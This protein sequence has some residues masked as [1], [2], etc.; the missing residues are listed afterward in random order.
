MKRKA[1]IILLALFIFSALM[2]FTS[3]SFLFPSEDGGKAPTIEKIEVI[4]ATDDYFESKEYLFN[5]DCT[6]PLALDDGEEYYVVLHYD[7]P[8]KLPISYV[9]INGQKINN[10]DFAQGSNTSKTYIYYKVDDMADS[11]ERSYVINSV[12]YVNGSST[13]K[14]KWNSEI[15]AEER[16]ARVTVRPYFTLTLNYMDA[17]RR[18]ASSADSKKNTVESFDNVYYNAEMS[19]YTVTPDYSGESIV[20]TK[21]GS[22]VFAGWFTKPNGEGELVTADDHY[23]F[24]CNVTLYAH[25]ERM[26]N[27]E[28]VELDEPVVYEYVSGNG[29]LKT[30]EFTSG[31]VITNRDFSKNELT[32][33]PTLDLTDTIVMETI[34]YTESVGP[35]GVAVYDVK[36]S[37]S[38]YPIVKIDNNA[39]GKFSTLT[40]VSVGQ[41]VEEIGY[42]AF[43]ACEALTTFNFHEDSV[44]KYIGDYA[45]ESTEALGINPPFTL[46]S[47]VEYLGNFAF[48]YSGWSN[49][50]N[51]GS[52]SGG[53]SVL[54]VKKDWKFIGYKCFFNTGFK[55]IVFEPGCYF[56][57]QIDMEEGKAL[58]SNLGYKTIQKDKNLI[59]ASLF[60]CNKNLTNVQFLTDEDENN[61]LNL[62]P[63]ACFDLFSWTSSSAMIDYI[64]FSEGLTYIGERAFFYQQKIPE[65]KLPASL[66]EVDID[67]FYEN[68]SV[69]V[70]TFGGNDSQLK[71]LHSNCFGNLIV[72]D[73]CEITSTVFHKYGSGVFRGCNRM[74]CV[75]FSGITEIPVGY[76][77]DEPGSDREVVVGHYQSDFLYATGEAGD[78]G[79]DD[80]TTYSSPL[81]VF[82]MQNIVD[83]F[84]EELKR[85]KEVHAGNTSSGTSAFSSSVFVHPLEN[86]REY[87][88]EHEGKEY[89][90]TV[91]VQ[92][93]FK[94]SNLKPT[95]TC[96]G[97]SLVYWSV[98]S[99]H[100]V[101][102]TANKLDLDYEIREVAMYSLPTS[103]K[104]VRVPACYTRLEH[105][106]FNGCTQLYEVKFDDINTLEYVGKYAFFGTKI[107][108]FTGGEN[109]TVI[110]DYAFRRCTALRWVDL[111]NTAIVNKYDGRQKYT[112]QFKYEYELEDNDRDDKN[113]LG[114]GVFQGCSALTWIYLPENIAQLRTGTFEGC[115]LLTTVII[116]AASISEETSATKNECFYEYNTPNSIY[117]AST[118]HNIQ[119]Y[120]T[121]TAQ[122]S[123]NFIYQPQKPYM[124]ITSDITT[125]PAN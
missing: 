94:A 33:N 2:I 30:Q 106:A 6:N 115:K 12:F 9:K 65:L 61:A 113:C 100:V 20:P 116:P 92:K 70:L 17:D 68:E 125:P 38:E 120:V 59:G 34:D 69:T 14:M 50:R 51:A 102:P 74:K 47:T 22:W 123:H 23:Y 81:R 32:H 41:F 72:L 27:V 45:F 107:T 63:D 3:C 31:A 93:I 46:P 44:L 54:R 35:Y 43:Q 108:E 84:K 29:A 11:E 60:A 37:S 1:L 101:L 112:D 25:Y 89:Q 66:E 110:G 4:K 95:N 98:R 119:I 67:A 57:D 48:R 62:I 52:A 58:E 18:M 114:N 10:T 99:E 97:Y 117:E 82:C 36:V 28:I 24:W 105:D 71:I 87:K 104:T 8:D 13:T 64:S 80:G 19:Y 21:A 42:C 75:I 73:S 90:V 26:Y 53:E 49:T 83:E 77:E 124:L 88:Y 16:V 55:S 96:I 91:A 76:K 122:D 56:E 109:L 39:F 79:N 121:S 7:N 103:V 85:G 78:T 118:V 5:K 111:H 15:T 86:L 40:N